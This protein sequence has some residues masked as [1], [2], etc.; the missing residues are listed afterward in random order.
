MAKPVSSI[1][2]DIDSKIGS[3]TAPYSISHAEVAQILKDITDLNTPLQFTTT[4]ERIAY[5]QNTNAQPFQIADDKED[6]NKYYINKA[7]TDWVLLAVGNSS[8]DAKTE[9]LVFDN[10][11][12]INLD[13]NTARKAKFGDAAIFIVETIDDDGIIRQKP[14]VEIKPNNITNT[15]AYIIDLGGG[16]KSGRLVI[17]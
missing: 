6:G 1:K 17:K 5:L 10:A 13:W 16:A 9:V 14:N 8:T 3:K 2:S 15:T 4:A 12:V 7:G 11:T